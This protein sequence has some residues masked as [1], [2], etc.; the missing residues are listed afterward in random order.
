MSGLISYI[1]KIGFIIIFFSF[2]SVC[3]ALFFFYADN[4]YLPEIGEENAFNHYP[5]VIL[6][7]YMCCAVLPL[8]FLI[9]LSMI[10]LESFIRKKIM[11][12]SLIVWLLSLSL[13][14]LLFLLKIHGT[15]ITWWL[16]D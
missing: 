10:I 15:P 8:S 9:T 2:F 1:K 13:F 12:K 7:G 3:L 4:G 11:L 6:S 5:L 14:L 16:W